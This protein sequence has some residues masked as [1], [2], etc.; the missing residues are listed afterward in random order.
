MR[1][2]FEGERDWSRIEYARLCA[3]SG[4]WREAGEVAG[5]SLARDGTLTSLGQTLLAA[6]AGRAALRRR[7][8]ATAD[9]RL[10]SCTRWLE[11]HPVPYARAHVLQL[12][13]ER[14]LVVDR[15]EE[16]GALAA[17][18]L[19]AYS[20]LPAP[21]DRAAAALDLARLAMN[22]AGGV[23][24]PVSEWLQDAA[25]AFERL[26][27]HPSRERALAYTVEWLERTRGAGPGGS[28]DRDLLKSV[29]RLLDSLSDLHDL[30]ERAMEMAVEYLDAER[31]V[32]LLTDG[33]GGELLPV[34]EH[35][36]VDADTRDRALSYSRR[37]VERVARSGGSLLIGDAPTD[38]NALSASVVGL[39]LRSI[40]CVPLYVG[41]H[42][43]GAVYLD[44][45]RRPDTFSDADR[46]LLEGFA[47]LM[48]LAIEKSRGHEETRRA[49]EALVGENLS[50][51]REVGA[52]FQPANFIGTSVAMQRV[53]AVVE[54][55]AETDSTVLITG[56]NGTGKELIARILHH[57]GSRRM[58]PFVYVNCGAIPENLLESELFGI[59][60]NVATGVHGREGRFVAADGGTLFLDE[61]GDMPLK[62]QVALLAAIA[63][64]EIT[65]VGGGKP[66]PVDVRIIA[67]T[68][69]DLRRQLEEGVF[70][71][72]LFYRLNVIPIEVPPLRERKADIPA[73]A[74]HFVAYFAEHQG[75][76]VPA[77]S[78]EF[79]AA[80]MSSDW[81][82]NVREMQNYMER[83][84][85]MSPGSVLY[86]N[87]LP[88]DL[89][90]RGHR[91]R[92]E[93]GRRLADLVEEM[94]RRVIREALDRC[95]GNQ[96]QAATELGMTEQSLRYRLRKYALSA[97][98]RIR[99]IRKKRRDSRK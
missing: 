3:A 98:R 67:A 63:N 48:A 18:A 54:R 11:A 8:F 79:I 72:D 78:P 31:G 50:L 36:A 51:R 42:V 87:P 33:Q 6:I 19:S 59:L 34:V 85:A 53:L 35:G 96:S 74:Q 44:D 84:M 7:D 60:A 52:R 95:G 45:S 62:Q 92:G 43:Y 13:A 16:G 93:R 37:V 99:R 82:G 5:R 77:L 25:G 55:A 58:K 64:R 56:E 14:A 9:A 41:G 29:A 91:P 49:N 90:G 81:P 65:P 30:T 70:R 61:I 75:R 66:I 22:A 97:T 57:G 40:V 23:L 68:N 24:A 76:P 94:E 1:P 89:E 69:R 73:L 17:E 26:G 38:P 21:A 4:R 80:L 83:V 39:R 46:G 15:F 32:L 2:G 12:R 86:P 27:D 71:E 20:A 47:H 88:R 10:A 28:L